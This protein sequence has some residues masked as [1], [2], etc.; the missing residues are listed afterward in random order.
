MKSHA[1]FESLETR[2]LCSTTA[3]LNENLVVNGDFEAGIGESAATYRA[4]SV[5]GWTTKSTMMAVAYGAPGFPSRA[6]SPAGGGN[7]FLSGIQLPPINA[8]FSMQAFQT[9]DVS[10]LAADIDGGRL[11]WDLS[12]DLGGYGSDR[13]LGT[14]RVSC[15][16][17]D[18][19]R[20]QYADAT[21]PTTF[22]RFDA[23]GFKTRNMGNIVAPGTRFLELWLYVRH[24]DG[25]VGDAYFNNISLK[26]APASNSSKG[27]ITGTIFN[28]ES[29]EGTQD[30]T[31]K[32]M[33][34]VTVF[35]DLDNDKKLDTN[36]PRATTKADGSY[37]I[38]GVRKGNV[39]LRV[40]A[41]ATFRDTSGARTMK[42]TGGVA[43]SS[44]N[45]NFG[46]SQT[47]LVSGSVFADNDGDGVRDA[48]EGGF[49]GERVLLQPAGIGRTAPSQR[50][51]S[52]DKGNY[53][54]I[55]DPRKYTLRI[56]PEAGTKQTIPTSSRI[57][58]SLAKGKASTN[59]VFG[60]ARI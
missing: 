27:F 43:Q 49:A 30:A 41:P 26:L 19:S 45:Q 28:D 2:S 32:G 59:N 21:G 10:S 9:I 25:D 16:G 1:A 23:T 6:Q 5:P 55:V 20:L 42:V 39:K 12:V 8:V 50:V 35:A 14:L 56:E 58:L 31:E 15:L 7:N 40:I 44:S 60:V 4:A 51:F 53:S 34:G 3:S 46:L 13:D 17:A 52:D 33:T 18:G 36:D 57:V 29:G 48:D 11:R 37:E 54:F 47:V 24:Q 22:E 38:A